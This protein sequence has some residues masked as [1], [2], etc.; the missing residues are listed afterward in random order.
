MGLPI[1]EYF[2]DIGTLENY[3]SAQADYATACRAAE[4]S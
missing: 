2:V 3:Y 4:E 1:S